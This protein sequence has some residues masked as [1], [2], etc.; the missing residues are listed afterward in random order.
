MHMQ[1][2]GFE[3]L[4]SSSQ[5]DNSTRDN[6]LG[7]TYLKLPLASRI[8]SA[9]AAFLVHVCCQPVLYTGDSYVASLK[10]VVQTYQDNV[11]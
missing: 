11:Y 6:T 9:V 3:R 10:G 4:P 8:A 7:G 2:S 5:R 1:Q